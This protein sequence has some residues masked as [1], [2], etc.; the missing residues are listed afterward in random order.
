MSSL[1]QTIAE[2]AMAIGLGKRR[3]RGT[4]RAMILRFGKAACFVKSMIG[5]ARYGVR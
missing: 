2:V 5:R 4:G 1:F 3:W